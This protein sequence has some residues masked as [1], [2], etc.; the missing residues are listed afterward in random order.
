MAFVRDSVTA[1][2][3]RA[4]GAAAARQSC[5]QPLLPRPKATFGAGI[6]GG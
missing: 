6:F 2:V 3:S 4:G 5:G 1:G